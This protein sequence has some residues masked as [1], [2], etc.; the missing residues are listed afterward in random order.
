MEYNTSESLEELLPSSR[1]ETGFHLG[2]SQVCVHFFF[3]GGA[4]HPAV[5]VGDV[6]GFQIKPGSPTCKA[7]QHPMDFLFGPFFFFYCVCGSWG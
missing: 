5:L 3:G 7:S 1:V 4:S 2:G 6:T